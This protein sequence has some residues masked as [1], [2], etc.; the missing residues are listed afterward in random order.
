MAAE[1]GGAA[2]PS[3]TAKPHPVYVALALTDR[4]GTGLSPPWEEP[5]GIQKRREIP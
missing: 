2:V 4:E 1:G 5:Q 3:G